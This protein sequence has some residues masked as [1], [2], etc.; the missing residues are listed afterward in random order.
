[1]STTTYRPPTSGK[2]TASMWLGI[3]SFPLSLCTFGV[4]SILAVILGHLA[5]GEIRRT[6]VSGHG[7]ALTG[8]ILGYGYGVFAVVTLIALALAR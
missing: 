5:L 1:M 2:A 6:G 8:L 7:R 4:L 3:L